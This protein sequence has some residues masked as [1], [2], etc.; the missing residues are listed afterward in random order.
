MSDKKILPEKYKYHYIFYNSK[1]KRVFSD[2]L[3]F[4]MNEETV[5]AYMENL[6][7]SKKL[8]VSRCA[9]LEVK[10]ILRR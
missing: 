8:D 3:H 2:W 6:R 7:E 5:R 4:E 1:G 9:V 10:K